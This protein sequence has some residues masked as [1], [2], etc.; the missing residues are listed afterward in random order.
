MSFLMSAVQKIFI[1]SLAFFALTAC[2]LKGDLYLPEAQPQVV[3][4]PV[5]ESAEI[6]ENREKLIVYSEDEYD[7]RED[8]NSFDEGSDSQDSAVK[9]NKQ[10]NPTP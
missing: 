8:E 2:G 1:T 9:K 7:Y 10:E 4:T 3:D 6:D 5:S